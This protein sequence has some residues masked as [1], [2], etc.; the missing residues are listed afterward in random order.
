MITEINRTRMRI[1]FIICL[2][3]FLVALS[4]LSTSQGIDTSLKKEILTK[5]DS[6]AAPAPSSKP[7]K[8]KLDSNAKSFHTPDETVLTIYFLIFGLLVLII[9]AF[10]LNKS[11]HDSS[12]SFKYFII[13]LLILGMLLLITIGLDKD[14]IS[15]AVGLFGTISGYLL[16]KT[17]LSAPAS[18]T[19]KNNNP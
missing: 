17:D 16:G 9:A 6:K 10:L 19:N 5:A 14:Q 4:S 3:I 15:P 18:K 13:V 8:P 7:K 1:L 11:T 12:T 2:S